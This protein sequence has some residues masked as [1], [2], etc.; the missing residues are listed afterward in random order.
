MPISPQRHGFGFDSK[1]D[2]HGGDDEEEEEEEDDFFN[3]VVDGGG[4]SGDGHRNSN[5]GGRSENYVVSNAR[6]NGVNGGGGDLICLSEA[7]ESVNGEALE[8]ELVQL[9]DSNEDDDEI[10]AGDQDPYALLA[11]KERLVSL[12]CIRPSP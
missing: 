10:T 3:G 5:G 11:Q 1:S 6:N 4:G 12:L 2:F 9:M 7:S 8:P